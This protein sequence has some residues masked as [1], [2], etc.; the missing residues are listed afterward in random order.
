MFS[1]GPILDTEF[2][3]E[4]LMETLIALF[5]KESER[6]L[7]KKEFNIYKKVCNCCI[8]FSCRNLIL[9][10]LNKKCCFPSFSSDR[11]NI[12]DYLR[13]QLTSDHTT[14]YSYY[15]NILSQPYCNMYKNIHKNENKI[16]FFF[17][18]TRQ[19]TSSF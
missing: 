2:F 19:K 11:R 6:Q 15:D 4:K 7:Q 12:S 9:K 16:W 18:E 14:W 5:S 10:R 17:I 3:K 8:F 13:C 1:I